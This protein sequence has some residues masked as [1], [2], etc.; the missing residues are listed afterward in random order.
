MAEENTPTTEPTAEPGG[1]QA[2]TAEMVE[3]ARLDHAVND[4]HRYKGQVK[5]LEDKIRI[6]EET[7]LQKNQ[8]WQKLAERYQQEA[9]QA[10]TK[11]DQIQNAYL[12]DRKRSAVREEALKLGLRSEAVSDLG[13][14]PLDEIQVQTT[15]DGQVNVLGADLFAKKLMATRPHWYGG[16]SAPQVATGHVGVV[17]GGSEVT[18]G[19]LAKAEREGRKSGDM[20]EYYRLWNQYKSQKRSV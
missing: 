2:P 14:L 12:T 8:E 6:H 20:S 15:S 3:K 4:V 5:E 17:E 11:T 9:D 18:T 10:R 13:L 1:A 19:M 16:K 7:V